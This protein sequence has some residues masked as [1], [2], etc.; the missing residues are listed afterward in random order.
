MPIDRDFT[1]AH[2]APEEG[3][4][5]SLYPDYT[6]GPGIAPGLLSLAGNLRNPG[7]R[8]RAR[9]LS[10][11]TAGGE[12]HPA[13]RT[14]RPPI[15]AETRFT[16]IAARLHRHTTVCAGRWPICHGRSRQLP[17]ACY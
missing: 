7:K 13:L 1:G 9:H 6:V 8:S 14:L 2:R 11:I 10:A 15:V 12:S 3:I 5:L 4:P 17:E 16:I